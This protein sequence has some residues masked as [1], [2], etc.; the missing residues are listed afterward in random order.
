MQLWFLEDVAEVPETQFIRLKVF[1]Q[2]E[3]QIK[4]FVLG[5]DR[6]VFEILADDCADFVVFV[7]VL[8]FA[9]MLAEFGSHHVDLRDHDLVVNFSPRDAV[10]FLLELVLEFDVS[11]VVRYFGPSF[12]IVLKLVLRFDTSFH[13]KSH[14]YIVKVVHFFYL[15]IYVVCLFLNFLEK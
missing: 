4:L 10:L 6:D 13:L 15:Y 3:H 9:E 1:F 8:G 12:V 11:R 14:N 2:Q 7:I 5:E